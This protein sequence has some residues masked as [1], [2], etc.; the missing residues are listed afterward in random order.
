MVLW[1]EMGETGKYIQPAILL[2]TKVILM[3]LD[4]L[5]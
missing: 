5:G 2:T 4:C 3:I 1:L